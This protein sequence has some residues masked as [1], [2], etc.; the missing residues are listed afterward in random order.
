MSD[1][2]DSD[3]GDNSSEGS[4]ASLGKQQ[5]QNSKSV[6]GGVSKGVSA[7]GSAGEDGGYGFI[8]PSAESSGGDSSSSS[9]GGSGGSDE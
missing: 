7:D 6:E 8:P 3:G 9:E 2:G 1:D 4:Q 5:R